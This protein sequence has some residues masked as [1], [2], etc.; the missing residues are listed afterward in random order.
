MAIPATE[1]SGR[2][3]ANVPEMSRK[4]TKDVNINGTNPRSPL[5]SAKVPKKRTQKACKR[6]RKMCQE[7]AKKLKQSERATPKGQ[8]LQA[9]KKDHRQSGEEAKRLAQRRKR[10][11][12]AHLGGEGDK[13]RKASTIQA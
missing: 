4:F 12:R 8:I 13:M 11:H 3:A 10:H 6:G 9:M 5:E 1:C 7:Y 2:V